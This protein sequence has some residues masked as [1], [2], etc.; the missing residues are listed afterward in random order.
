MSNI[1][2]SIDKRTQLVGENRMELLL[3]TL[4][5]KQ[6]YGINVFKVREIIQSL[7]ITLI[8]MRHRIVRGIAH[9][10][11]LTIPIIDL[12]LALGMTSLPNAKEPFIIVAE[13]NKNIQ[14]FMVESVVRIVNVSWSKVLPPPPGASKY[15]YLTAVTNIDDNLVEII[16]VEK[17]LQEIIPFTTEVSQQQKDLA[18]AQ[19]NPNLNKV[20]ICD[21]SIVARKQIIQS[22]EQLKV[23]L[24]I[25]NDGKEALEYLKE[26]TKDG[27]NIIDKLLLL[28]SDV[29]MPEMDGYTLTSMIRKDPNLKDLHIVLHTSLSGIFNNSL[30]K[31]VGANQFIA[32]FDP[33]A[34]A[35]VVTK[36]MQELR[37]TQAK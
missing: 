32:K 27:S 1:L 3:F 17:V 36:R 12:N 16:D 26:E 30:I 20:L 29:E 37:A 21:D 15:S 8:P 4:Q 18:I 35:E 24:I 23:E 9:I 33:N 31:K 10:R 14:G 25:K 5:T 34:L 2:N 19:Q 11:G 6:L 13:Y 28:I 7:P 22:L